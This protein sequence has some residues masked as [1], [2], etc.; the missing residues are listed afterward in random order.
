MMRWVLQS[1]GFQNA[2]YTGFFKD[3]GFPVQ[4]RNR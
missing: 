3:T 1:A 2:Y 4:S